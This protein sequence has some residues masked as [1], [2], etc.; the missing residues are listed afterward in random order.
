MKMKLYPS[1]LNCDLM[2]FADELKAIKD[3]DAVH[4]DV[5]DNHFVPNLTWGLPT[6]K[7]MLE[8]TKLPIDAHLMIENPDRWAL[9]YAK[10]GCQIVCFHL[11]ASRAPVRTA[12]I[13][14]SLGAK[15]GIALNP[16]TPASAVRDILPR[17]DQVTVMSVEPGFGGQSFIPEV[18][19]KISK[20]RKYIEDRRLK[21]DIQVDGGMT[22]DTLP[23]ALDAGAN[24]IV[25]G[26]YIFKNQPAKAIETLRK[27]ASA[28]NH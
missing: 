7:A 1:V 11:E 10:A 22:A 23:L 4:L 2:N 28:H 26:S 3:A 13:L 8:V 20:L 6:A 18:L 12:E 5:M 17:F 9:D 24:V 16:A 25:A 15:V 21:I 19:P 27:V 14:H